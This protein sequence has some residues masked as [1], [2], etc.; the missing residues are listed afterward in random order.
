MT[1]ATQVLTA[2]ATAQM[3]RCGVNI[4]GFDQLEPADGRLQALVWSWADAAA[5]SGGPC[6]YQGRDTRFHSSGCGTPRHFACLGLGQLWH[7]TRAAGPWRKGDST[8]AREFPGSTF[9]VP[10]NGFRNATLA[11]AKTRGVGDVWL[12]YRRVGGRW[13]S[14][15][16]S[17]TLPHTG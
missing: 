3:V 4:I 7:V 15:S 1:G 5:M 13:T 12:R 9:G 6:A 14:A 2:P 11:A 17:A 16:A 8:C 10:V